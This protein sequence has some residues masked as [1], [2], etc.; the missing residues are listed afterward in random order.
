V[1]QEFKGKVA[2][3]TGGASGIGRATAE[4]LAT[5]GAQVVIGDVNVERGEALAN[6]IGEAAAFLRTDVSRRNEVQALVD[7]AV[8]RFGAL[9]VMFNNAGVGG[10]MIPHFL[11]DDLQDWERV[12]GVNL[13]GAVFGSHAAARHMAAHGGGVIINNASVAGLMSGHTF[14]PYRASKAAIINFTK[15]IA[16]DLAGH[17]IRV[18]ALAPGSLKTE[19]TNF[20]EPG[21]SEEDVARLRVAT[22]AILTVYQPWKRQGLARDAAEAVAFLASDRAAQIT[23]IVL[24]VDGGITAGDAVNRADQILAARQQIIDDIR[25][26]EGR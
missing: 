2:I 16:I 11:D 17:G 3:V 24:P 6:Q 9:H 5:R 21:W 18:N 26:R 7:L 15:S 12:L 22:D 23:G 13:M 4:L 25:E 1:T 8:S 10:R 14:L 20:G 19:I